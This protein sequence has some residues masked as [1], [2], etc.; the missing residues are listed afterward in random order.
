VIVLFVLYF[1]GKCTSNWSNTTIK[2]RVYHA[3]DSVT[4]LYDV[5]V[6]EVNCATH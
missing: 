5:V 1:K 3:S 2:K 6:H 4:H